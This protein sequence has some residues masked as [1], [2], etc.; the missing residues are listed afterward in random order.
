MHFAVLFI[1]LSFKNNKVF[2]YVPNSEAP[3]SLPDTDTNPPTLGTKH[4]TTP[5]CPAQAQ[6]QDISGKWAQLQEKKK[7]ITQCHLSCKLHHK[8]GNTDNSAPA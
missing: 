8:W 3:S 1:F 5:H 6:L 4:T 2:I 7:N